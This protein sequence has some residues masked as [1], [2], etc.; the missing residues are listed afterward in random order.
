[1]RQLARLLNTVRERLAVTRSIVQASRLQKIATF[2]GQRD[3]SRVA[4]EANGLNET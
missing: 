2:P 3:D 4:V 1:M